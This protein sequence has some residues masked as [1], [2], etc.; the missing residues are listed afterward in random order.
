MVAIGTAWHKHRC[1]YGPRIMTSD[2]ARSKTPHLFSAIIA[3]VVMIVLLAAGRFFAIHLEKRT[4]RATAPRP[5]SLKNQGLAF[6]RVALKSAD[7]LPIYGSS[8]VRQRL[9]ENAFNFFKT[10]PT[11]FQ[12]SPVG[13]AGTTSLIILQKLAALAPDA[14]GKK[15]AISLS[16]VWFFSPIINPRF[17]EGNFSV[18]AASATVFSS[19]LDFELKRDIAARMLQYPAVSAETPLLRFALERLASGQWLDRVVF[20]ML[21]PLG[22]AQN[23]LLDL[24]DHFESAMFIFQKTTSAPQLHREALDW[25]NLMARAADDA[26]ALAKTWTLP[27]PDDTPIGHI[28]DSIFLTRMTQAHEWIDLELLLRTLA[29]LHAQPLLINMPIPGVFWEQC[30]V[31]WSARQVYYNKVRSLAQRY[32]CPVADF[33]AHDGDADFLMVPRNHPSA[34]GWMF[35]NRALDNFFHGRDL[36]NLAAR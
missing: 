8:E 29:Q 35:Y 26:A 23:L 33:A 12:V 20:W 7:V 31:S 16:P 34:K 24:Q 28:S 17:Y 11:G 9:R 1:P 19:A 32:D 30:G 5:F 4:V 25:P 21:W 18:E 6:Q 14:R 10:A 15:I 3:L 22:K 36:A 27:D 13:V 2:N